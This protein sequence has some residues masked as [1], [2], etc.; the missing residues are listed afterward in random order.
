MK[1]HI[2]KEKAILVHGGMKYRCESCGKSW[3]MSLEIG[4]EDFGK[5]GR[6]HQPAPFI[7]K[8][9]CGGLAQDIS[10]YLPFPAVRPLLPGL[11]YFAYDSSKRDDACG[12][13]R[14]YQP[15]HEAATC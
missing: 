4:V 10:G 9:D 15:E 13:P 8:C 1:A 6:P 3:F 7:I 2:K 14:T 5:H 11:R 12:Q